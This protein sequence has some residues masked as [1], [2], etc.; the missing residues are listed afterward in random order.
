[1]LWELL[2]LGLLPIFIYRKTV[3]IFVAYKQQFKNY[4]V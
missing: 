1:M 4:L 3:K 2:L